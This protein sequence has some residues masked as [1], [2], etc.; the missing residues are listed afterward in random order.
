MF[1]N[2]K[3]LL[4]HDLP[5]SIPVA[6]FALKGFVIALGILFAF[7]YFVIAL[8]TFCFEEFFCFKISFLHPLGFFLGI[9]FC[10][11]FASHVA[12]AC[13]FLYSAFSFAFSPWVKLF[14]MAGLVLYSVTFI[15]ALL[16][17][18]FFLLFGFLS[19]FLQSKNAVKQENAFKIIQII[20]NLCFFFTR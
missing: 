16:F 11:S 20:Q 4:T 17:F 14:L 19:L 12:V 3:V 13:A 5:L 7:E 8:G 6:L 18:D 15:S 1:N 2:I 9:F 10:S